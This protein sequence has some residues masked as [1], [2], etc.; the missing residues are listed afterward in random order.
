[1]QIIIAGRGGQGILLLTKVMGEAAF[2]SGLPVLSSETHG[3]ALRG[4]SVITHL[5]VGPYRSPLIPRESADVVIG[6]DEDEANNNIHFLRKDGLLIINHAGNGDGSCSVDANR[7][8]RELGHIQWSNM[9]LLGFAVS[10]LGHPFSCPAVR[11]AIARVSPGPFLS[12]NL[13]AFDLG[14]EKGSHQERERH[15]K[16]KGMD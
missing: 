15:G 10:R 2:L 9:V 16:G 5:K 11:E 1:M 8:A 14:F 12:H 6:M 4:G 3:M 13:K 7:L